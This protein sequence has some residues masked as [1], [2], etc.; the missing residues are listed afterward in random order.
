VATATLCRAPPHPRRTGRGR[1][2]PP[3]APRATVLGRWARAAPVFP[4]GAGRSGVV[5]PGLAD[6]VGPAT[7]GGASGGVAGADRQR[8]LVCAVL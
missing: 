8:G 2:G 6:P 1:Y 5:P 3:A 7:T 4:R